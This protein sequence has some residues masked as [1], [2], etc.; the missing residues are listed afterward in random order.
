MAFITCLLNLDTSPF[1]D[2]I[3]VSD[4]NLYKSVD[5]RNKPGGDAD[6]MQMFN[7]LISDLE[8][9]EIPFSGTTFT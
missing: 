8:L 1:E 4:F 9:V 3:L 2:W 6:D 5:D 7:N